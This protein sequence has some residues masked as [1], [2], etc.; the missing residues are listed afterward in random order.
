MYRYLMLPMRKFPGHWKGCRPHRGMIRLSVAFIIQLLEKST[1]KPAWE[2]VALAPHDVKKLL[3]QWPR[4]AIQ[5][6]VLKR[7]FESADG[8]TVRCQVV[9]LTI[10]REEFLGLA[11]GGITDGH[12]G[13]RRSAAVVQARLLALM[14]FRPGLLH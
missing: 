6:G 9:L 3:A 14:V 5:Q 10:L 4:L 8:L 13:R 11:H 2:E 1:E 12:F 7:R